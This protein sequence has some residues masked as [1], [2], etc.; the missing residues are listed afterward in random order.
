MLFTISFHYLNA[1]VSQ[2]ACLFS[3]G[4]L[5]TVNL[6]ACRKEIIISHLLPSGENPLNAR[7]NSD[8]R[9]THA[10]IHAP[11]LLASPEPL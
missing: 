1:V 4:A 9:H 5:Y 11:P 8:T 3:T 6:C 7:K 2:K 10:H